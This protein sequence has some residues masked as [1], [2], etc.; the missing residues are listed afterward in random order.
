M[1]RHKSRLFDI[2]VKGKTEKVIEESFVY[3]GLI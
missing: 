3:R 1:I 2:L